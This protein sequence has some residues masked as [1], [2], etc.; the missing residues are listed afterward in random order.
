MFFSHGGLF[1]RFNRQK[2]AV[3][4]R[5][6]E[7]GDIDEEYAEIGFVP[8][9]CDP[10]PQYD[11]VY[12]PGKGTAKGNSGV[13]S[14]TCNGHDYQNVGNTS[15]GG[16]SSQS[17]V[18]KPFGKLRSMTGQLFSFFKKES[19]T[20]QSE[21]KLTV[22]KPR[23]RGISG[24]SYDHLRP[25]S[26]IIVY[27]PE[28]NDSGHEYSHTNTLSEKTKSQ[29][30]D[31]SKAIGTDSKDSLKD[32]NG[33]GNEDLKAVHIGDSY[34]EFKF[35]EVDSNQLVKTETKHDE[36][37]RPEPPKRP[38][39]S[40]AA[41]SPK[42]GAESQPKYDYAEGAGTPRASPI[43]K[44][45]ESDN[46]SEHSYKILEP[47]STYDYA[48]CSDNEM[49]VIEDSY[50]SIYEDVDA[51]NTKSASVK[52]HKSATDY[53]VEPSEY[54]EPIESRTRT[55]S[56]PG[57]L[58]T[59]SPGYVNIPKVK[60]ILED[61]ASG[62]TDAKKSG[63]QAAELTET[64]GVVKSD[65]VKAK[66]YEK[67]LDIKGVRKMKEMFEQRES[68]SD[69]SRQSSPRQVTGKETG[70]GL[71]AMLKMNK[72]RRKPDSEA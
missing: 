48:D 6:E 68:D 62:D 12:V 21:S 19:A 65:N 60:Q 5:Y 22:A 71:G 56:S 10:T 49:Q 9:V 59:S 15:G 20:D 8:D 46:T 17:V 70:Q 39:P 67:G 50:G 27:K 26:G 29:E 2:S 35:G 38:P 18:K 69:S 1:K 14:P 66:D 28:M 43:P 44:S 53:Q 47:Q 61:K 11:A 42:H 64:Q 72:H 31:K 24:G 32:T 57:M 3:P 30:P 33:N 25:A 16:Q 58:G 41:L 55:I 52:K 13:V 34:I 36:N 63:K 7:S 40:P 54:L 37:V 23:E 45:T 4:N 51:E